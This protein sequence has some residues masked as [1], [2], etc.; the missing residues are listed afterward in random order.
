MLLQSY[1]AA[2]FDDFA[3]DEWALASAIELAFELSNNRIGERRANDQ[4][5][6]HAHVEDTKHL[7]TID[8]AVRLKE[9]KDGWDLPGAGINYSIEIVRKHAH[10]IAR[11]AA[12]SDVGHGRNNSLDLVAAQQL[13]DRL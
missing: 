7:I 9:I 3:H 6:T 11:Y 4:H 12:T 2:A 8:L 1:L 5:E 13:D 10:N